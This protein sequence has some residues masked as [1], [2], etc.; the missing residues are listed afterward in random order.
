MKLARGG[1]GHAP[2]PELTDLLLRTI[3]RQTTVFGRPQIAAEL[4]AEI[5]LDPQRFTTEVSRSLGLVWF[6]QWR[7]A[8]TPT[9]EVLRGRSAPTE[10][11]APAGSD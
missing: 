6:A 8:L 4:E 10:M 11:F 7:L 3:S 2:T 5:A 9:S 1:P